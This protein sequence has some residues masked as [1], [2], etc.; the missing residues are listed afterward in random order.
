[1]HD[2]VTV[3]SQVQQFKAKG[4]S[5]QV[6]GMA[7]RGHLV[8]AL[9]KRA[10]AAL[11]PALVEAK[12]P[13]NEGFSR[14]DSNSCGFVTRKMWAGVLRIVLRLGLPWL[15][16]RRL[17]VYEEVDERRELICYVKFLESYR[18][19]HHEVTKPDLYPSP[20]PVL[21]WS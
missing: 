19:V 2:V 7:G 16:L 21:N 17:L 3:L 12:V 4:L 20:K 14:V 10:V 15:S 13:L 8:Q 11:A 1:M 18:V 9:E 5:S 6:A